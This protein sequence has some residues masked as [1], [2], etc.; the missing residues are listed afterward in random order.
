[1]KTHLDYIS[2]CRIFG[3]F[4]FESRT[5]R[6]DEAHNWQD[7]SGIEPFCIAK[8]YAMLLVSAV[9]IPAELKIVPD[10]RRFICHVLGYGSTL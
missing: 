10:Q 8:V 2:Y 6:N 1:M 7:S 9:S 5:F 3:L 4:V